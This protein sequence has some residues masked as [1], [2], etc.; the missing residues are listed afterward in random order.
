MPKTILA[1]LAAVAALTLAA[2]SKEAPPTTTAETPPE[3]TAEAPGLSI[4]FEK[5]QLDNGLE[6]VLHVDKSDPIVAINLAAHVGS[7]REL[8]GRT[9]FA[10]LFEHLLFLDSENLGYGGLDEMNTRIGGA[11]TNGFTTSDMTQYFQAVPADALEKIIWAE[12]DKLGFFINTVTQPVIDNEKQVVKNEKRQ[13]VDNQPYGHNFDLIGK[14]IYP[15][16]HPYSWQVI[17]SLADLDAATLQDVKDFYRRW[18]VPNNVTLT[19]TGDFDP[20]LAKILVEKYFGEIPKGEEVAPRQPRKAV[21]SET[22]SLMHEDSFA[23][24]P[25]LTMIWP[26]VEEYHPDSYALNILAEYL[27]VG[28]RAPLNEILIDETKLTSSVA[29]FHFAKELAGEFYLQIGATADGDLD[30]LPPAINDAF[31]RFEENGISEA[32]LD[33]I[34][35]GLEVAFY[36]QIQSV[37]GKAIQLSQYNIFTGDPGFFAK[38]I[39]AI[40]AVSTQDVMDVY[41]MY[42]KDKHHVL[43]SFVPNGKP[44]L[45]LAGAQPAAVVEEPIVQGAEAEVAFDPTQRTFQPTPSSFD[46]TAEPE[47]GQPYTLPAPEVWRSQMDNGIATYGI[48]STETPLIFFALSIAAGRDRGDPAKPA[49]A[50]LTA[51]LLQK[52]TANRST[53]EL[54]DAIK[55]LGSDISISVGVDNTTILGNTLARNFAATIALVEEMLLEPRWDQQEFDLLKRRQLD[56]LDQA[57]GNPNAIAQRESAKLSYPAGH[58]LSYTTYGT[59]EKLETVT[60]DDL[61]AF[62]TTNYSPVNASL[63]IVGDTSLEDVNQAFAGISS[64]WNTATP[65][66]TAL[67]PAR[68]VEA[69]EIYFYDIPGAKQSILVIQRPSLAATDLDYPLAGAMNFLLGNIYTSRLNTELRVNKGYTYGIR[70]GFAGGKKEGRFAITSSVRSNVTKESMELIRDIVSDYGPGFSAA[71]LSTLKGALLRGQARQNETLLAKLSML[72]AIANFGYPDD[73]QAQNASRIEAMTLPDFKTLAATYLRPDA[74]NWLVVGDAET[75]AARLSELGYGEPVL[76]E[77]VE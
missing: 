36:N 15:A 70:S 72:G 68:P 39:G 46:R 35:A 63:R 49:V 59:R 32:D 60:L 11:G 64:S 9:G 47:F 1:S 28:K 69:S 61:K 48:E 51:D 14:T 30:A 37:L 24:V 50:A 21:L 44:E 19:L 27:S 45:A 41:N 6:V 57:A 22:I 12:A 34:K 75:Q 31:M 58:I 5:Y 23:T 77:K 25:Q 56:Q 54:E 67:S 76:L 43:T 42:I 10:H 53:A 40:Q 20:A 74:M 16:D 2:C 38:E 73:Y 4:E 26:G 52:G 33:R 65:G 7:S 29:A 66:Q 18:Y 71:D 17:G 62:Y 8:Q 55:A 13:R 3:T